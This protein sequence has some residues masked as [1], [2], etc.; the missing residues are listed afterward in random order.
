MSTVIITTPN[1][2]PQPPSGPVNPNDGTLSCP[3]PGAP[4]PPEEEQPPVGD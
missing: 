3:T 2:N 4:P 1:P